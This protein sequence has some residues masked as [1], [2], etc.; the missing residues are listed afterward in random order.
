MCCRCNRH[1]KQHNPKP[2]RRHS[3]PPPLFGCL[4][5]KPVHQP[6][7]YTSP[8]EQCVTPSEEPALSEVEWE[9]SPH[10]TRTATNTRGAPSLRSK[11]GNVQSFPPTKDSSS[12]AKSKDPHLT[13]T[14]V[15]GCP[16]LAKQ[17]WE[18]TKLPTH[19]RFVIVSKVERPASH[20]HPGAGVP[21]PCEARVGYSSEAQTFLRPR[22]P[23]AL[24]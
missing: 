13:N 8:T 1:A 15:P 22:I 18:C 19:K 10:F 14:R 24:P 5:R 20:Q 21:H 16:I 9:E 3:R 4:S 2:S 7:Q 23:S 6:S 11:G 17:G 12:S